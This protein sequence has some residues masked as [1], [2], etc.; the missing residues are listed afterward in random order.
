VEQVARFDKDIDPFLSAQMESYGIGAVRTAA[1]LNWRFVAPASRQYAIH[2]VREAAQPVAYAVLRRMQMAGFDVLALVDFLFDPRRPD[3][4]RTLLY[5]VHRAA[6][7]ARVDLVTCLL[8]PHSPLL[9]A[10]RR[11]RFLRTPES[12]QLAVHCPAGS[13]LRF[14]SRSYPAWHITWFDHDYV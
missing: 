3:V 6:L 4:A 11:F 7:E 5:A 8:N 2:I 10:L 12:F 14:D 1:I 13:P 9:P